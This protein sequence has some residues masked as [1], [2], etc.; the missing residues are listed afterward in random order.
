MAR[1]V[2]PGLCVLCGGEM[3]SKL[4]DLELWFDGS[5]RV[6]KDVPARVCRQ[7]GEKTI[8]AEIARQI[9]ELLDSGMEPYDYIE[10]PVYKLSEA[11]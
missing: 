5:L 3:E 7:C 2:T 11:A 1:K 9:D 6:I 4:V 8:S 10:V